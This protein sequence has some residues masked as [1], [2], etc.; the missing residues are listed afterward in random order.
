MGYKESIIALLNKVYRNCTFTDVL[1]TPVGTM[2][3]SLYGVS[4]PVTV[5]VNIA[6]NLIGNN[7]FLQSLK[8]MLALELKTALAAV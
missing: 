6:G 8:N 3:S 1:L 5:N 7:E 4:K 2:I